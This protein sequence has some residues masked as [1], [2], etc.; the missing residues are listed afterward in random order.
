[1][2]K[3]WLLARVCRAEQ[4]VAHGKNWHNNLGPVVGPTAAVKKSLQSRIENIV[5]HTTLC[6]EYLAEATTMYKL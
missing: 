4:L 6:T 2:L 1:M 3:L 5:Y